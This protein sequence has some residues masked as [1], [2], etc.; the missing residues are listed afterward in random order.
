MTEQEAVDFAALHDRL[1]AKAA[2]CRELRKELHELRSHAQILQNKLALAELVL[3]E[4]RHPKQTPSP[5]KAKTHPS[6]PEASSSLLLSD[7]TTLPGWKPNTP[8]R[9]HFDTRPPEILF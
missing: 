7:R 6:H 5:T 8:S 2:E 9:D 4:L 3:G 1:A